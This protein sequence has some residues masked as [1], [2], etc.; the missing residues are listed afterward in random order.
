MLQSQYFNTKLTKNHIEQIL[1]N[2]NIKYTTMRN[3]IENKINIMI[4]AFST[5]ILSFLNNMEEIAEQRQKLKTLEYNQ[6]EL[7]SVREK[8]KEKIHELTKLKREIE[9][10]KAENKR[11]KNENNNNNSNR[12]RVFS[13]TFRDNA[14]NNNLSFNQTQKKLNQTKSF[15]LKTDNKI[16]NTKKRF[17]SPPNTQISR[18]KT[19]ISDSQIFDDKNNIIKIKL[20][21]FN[22]SNLS[23]SLN[24]EIKTESNILK[25][26]KLKKNSKNKKDKLFVIK[27]KFL[28]KNEELSKSLF[29]NSNKT[30]INVNRGNNKQLFNKKTRNDKQINKRIGTNINIS[31]SEIIKNENESI[32]KKTDKNLYE[33]DSES[34]NEDIGNESKISS[35]KIDEEINEINDIEG[36]ILNVMEKIKEFKNQNNN[37]KLT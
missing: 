30:R 1:G 4:K 22:K 5:D 6:N 23:N 29:S 28:T 20:K 35:D 8:L 27:N 16:I 24:S 7:D 19:K 17:K 9:L 33:K 3:E 25:N 31:N 14:I 11:L 37:D 2:Y 10:L 13:P 34:S 18:F 26:S 32:I 36:D 15:L 12:K 21:K